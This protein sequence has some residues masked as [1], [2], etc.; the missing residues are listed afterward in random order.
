[1]YVHEPLY[2]LPVEARGGCQVEGYSNLGEEGFCIIP[3]ISSVHLNRC[4]TAKEFCGSF[5]L[6]HFS[7]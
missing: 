3:V 7:S 1:M 5:L 4:R 6:K 2:I